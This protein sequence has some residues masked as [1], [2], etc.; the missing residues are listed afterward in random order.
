MIAEINPSSAPGLTPFPFKIIGMPQAH[1]IK[2]VSTD[3]GK[4][5][6]MGL[7]RKMMLMISMMVSNAV[8]IPMVL[9]PFILSFTVMGSSNTKC[10]FPMNIN[11]MISL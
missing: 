11:V 10:R 9:S 3:T 4:N 8:C 1:D 2:N 6:F 7:N 5:I